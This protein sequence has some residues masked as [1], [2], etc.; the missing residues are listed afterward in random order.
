MTLQE[1]TND[2][3]VENAVEVNN[4]AF[5][6]RKQIIAEVNALLLEIRNQL[7]IG[8]STL[9]MTQLR[10]MISEARKL[11]K[12]GYKIIRGNIQSDNEELMAVDIKNQTE[13]L[14][15]LMG[16]Y[17][18]DYK[19][20]EPSLILTKRRIKDIPVEDLTLESWFDLWG[21]KTSG[22][23]TGGLFSG[24]TVDTTRESLVKDVFGTSQQP[25]NY[26]TFVRSGVDF[27]A[28]LLSSFDA[29]SAG[30]A[31]GIVKANP[32]VITGQVW[33][34]CLC[35]TTCASC[36]SLHGS[37]RY[38]N[39]K[40]ETGG[41]EI[42]LHPNCLCFWSYVYKDVRK[43][44]AKVPPEDK[45]SINSK[46][47]PKKF[48]VWYNSLSEKRKI[49]LLGKTRV[50]MLES[51]DITLNKLLSRNNRQPYTLNELRTKGYRVP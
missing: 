9:N 11:F 38:I 22:K 13:I 1:D 19:V 48:D 37:T 10:N 20:K 30:V 17:N 25:L 35:P 49:E 40:D 32:D 51:G 28:L 43:M 5:S 18:V 29:T 47:T 41:N 31:Q 23:I 21:I 45:N 50:A 42:P 6:Q 8:P 12:E 14:Q 36:A 27:N 24:Y 16:E 33:N 15:G 44:N 3:M 39:G 34:S 7:L 2:Y 46:N 26:Q 4:Y